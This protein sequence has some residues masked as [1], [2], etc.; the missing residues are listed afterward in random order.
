MIVLH[1]T[2]TLR[3][4]HNQPYYYHLS[5]SYTTSYGLV[6]V[7]SSSY[8]YVLLF[9]SYRVLHQYY[10]VVSQLVTSCYDS[11]NSSNSKYI[12]QARQVTHMIR[13][14]KKPSLLSLVLEQPATTKKYI[15]MKN[16]S[17]Y[18]VLLH[19]TLHIATQQYYDSTNSTA[20]Y[21]ASYIHI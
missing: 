13:R 15:A 9:L 4:Y 20:C 17:S 11:K 18:T 7:R 21:V 1:S 3:S 6:V 16:D 19:T 5:Y 12:F 2:S 14:D 10:C 8:I